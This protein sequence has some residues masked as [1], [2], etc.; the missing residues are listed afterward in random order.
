M[1]NHTSNLETNITSLS[2]SHVSVGSQGSQGS[3]GPELPP[4]LPQLVRKQRLKALQQQHQRYNQQ[5]PP[6]LPSKYIRK[7]NKNPKPEIPLRK[8]DRPLYTPSPPSHPPPPHL[9][10]HRFDDN[11][12]KSLE[13]KIVKPGNMNTRTPS[14]GVSKALRLA[15]PVAPPYHHKYPLQNLSKLDGVTPLTTPLWRRSIKISR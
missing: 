9:L 2:P 12:L 6:T 1:P 5:I 8:T 11:F 4:R 13:S 15:V 14:Y 7:K 3:P 10:K